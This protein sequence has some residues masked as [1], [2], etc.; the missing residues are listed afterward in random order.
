MNYVHV[1]T[2]EIDTM[3]MSLPNVSRNDETLHVLH[4]Q[5]ANK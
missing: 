5:Q 3:C 2:N 4:V 1:Q